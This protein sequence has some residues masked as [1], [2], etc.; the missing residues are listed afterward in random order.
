MYDRLEAC[1]AVLRCVLDRPDPL[2]P[3]RVGE[4]A[5]QAGLTT[6][7]TSRIAAELARADVV[8]PAAVYGAYRIGRRSVSLSGRAAAPYAQ[9]VAFGLTL[10]AQ[11][12]GETACIVADF[13]KGPRVVAAVQSVWT[14]HVSAQVGDVLDDRSGAAVRALH[15]DSAA[16]ASDLS[17]VESSSEGV[18]E[19]A[20][21]LVGT[22]GTT[23]AVL[24]V[25][26]PAAR[27][28]EMSPLVR[29]AVR[30]AR[31]H[32]E[33]SIAKIDDGAWLKAASVPARQVNASALE[34][35]IELLLH[36]A[37]AGQQSTKDLAQALG[38]RSDRVSRLVEACAEAGLVRLIDDGRAARLEWNVHGWHRSVVDPT[39][40]GRG[41]DLVE[42]AATRAGATAYLTVR[43]GM[44]SLT[45][46][47]TIAERPLSMRSWLGRTSQIVAADGGPLLAMDF[48]DAE[49]RRVFPARVSATA[50]H[51]PLDL[52]TFLREVRPARRAG[53]LV[54]REFGEN[55]LT[56]VAAP[57]Y[58]ASGAVAA[59]ACLVGP[60]DRMESE[61][62]D[63]KAVARDLAGEVSQLLCSPSH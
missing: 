45:V 47:E 18:S 32:V 21:P 46:A 58:D 59:A 35:A 62:D 51:T 39:L 63:L 15:L 31:Q 33:A 42:S 56:S 12:T 37:G 5:L 2:E 10:A 8:E 60:C 44:R 14:L 11:V 1:L 6:S 40:R 29:R 20:T 19:I 3:I 24:V 30:A 41:Q 25:R 48:A 27:A 38:I 49:I 13:P 23:P 28:Q 17:V 54:I 22:D 36:L 43:R 34:T 4:L 7:T 53:L 52:E 26:F 57:V 16:R 61:L 50:R 9:A 55:G